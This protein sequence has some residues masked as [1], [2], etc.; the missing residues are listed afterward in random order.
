MISILVIHTTHL[1]Y[2]CVVRPFFVSESGRYTIFF[3]LY[4][5]RD[6]GGVVVVFSLKNLTY[7]RN[8]QPFLSLF[9]SSC[10]DVFFTITPSVSHLVMLFPYM[11][12]VLLAILPHKKKKKQAGFFLLPLNHRQQHRF[13]RS[14]ACLCAAYSTAFHYC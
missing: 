2:L 9:F 12:L 3:V 8:V 11:V 13:V 5:C 6:D 1:H 14:L 7:F 4:V 10:D